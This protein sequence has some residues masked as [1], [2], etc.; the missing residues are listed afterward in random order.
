MF[1]GSFKS[2]LP[3]RIAAATAGGTASASTFSP[4]PRAIAGLQTG[5]DASKPHTGNRPVQPQP[6]PPERL[7]AECI[8]PENL[9]ALFSQAFGMRIDIVVELGR[10]PLAGRWPASTGAPRATIRSEVANAPVVTTISI[11]KS[12]G[13][14]SHVFPPG[15]ESAAVS[16]SGRYNQ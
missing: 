5:A 1:A 9:P 11:A 14:H 7:T 15:A 12:V 13:R 3:A 6:A 16:R 8:E 4:R 2:T 10:R